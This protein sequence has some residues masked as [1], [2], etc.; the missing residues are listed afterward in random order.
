MLPPRS[1]AAMLALSSIL[2]LE[3][4]LET[5]SGVPSWTAE[6]ALSLPSFPSLSSL[7]SLI[8]IAP[9]NGQAS[10]PTLQEGQPRNSGMLTS[11]HGIRDG[12]VGL[13]EARLRWGGPA[14]SEQCHSL[15]FP[16]VLVTLLAGGP[17]AGDDCDEPSG[18]GD[19]LIGLSPIGVTWAVS[20]VAHTLKGGG[21]RDV[22][23]RRE[24]VLTLLELMD[25]VHLSH[26][27][28]WEGNSGG[29]D[30]LRA[31]V[32]EIVGVLEFPFVQSQNIPGSP[33]G[34]VMNSNANMLGS[35]S[36]SARST[37]DTGIELARA[38][39]ANMPHY[40]QL[41]QEVN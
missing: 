39:T 15:G 9:Q 1:A 4:G 24:P 10:A 21:Y 35:S 6:T 26:L 36:P 18:L 30:G 27:Q 17:R 5:K 40:W 16:L 25:R 41:L 7:R 28:L 8:K 11:W 3:Q 32:H 12:C 31:L 23:F 33:S 13:L 14:T 20:A 38:M 34:S 19:D 2:A 22:L 37:A 29:R